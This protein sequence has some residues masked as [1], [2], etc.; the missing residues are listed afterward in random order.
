MKI[1]KILISQPAPTDIDQ[2]PYRNLVNE[3]HLDLTFYKFFTV[4]G[5]PASEFRKNRIH[6]TEY[7]AVIFNSKY[8]VDHF[9][10][11]AKELRE[12]IPETMKYFCCTESIS[13]YLQTYIQYRKRK[14]FFGQQFFADLV[15]VMAKHREENYLFP[16]SDEKQTEYTKLLDKAKF[17]YK[18]A[19]MYR[20]VPKDL[21]QFNI[22]DF[23]LVALFA[24]IGVRS[25]LQNFPNFKDDPIPVAAFGTTTHAALQAAGIKLTIVAPT[26]S[27]PSMAMAIENYINGKQQDAVIIARPMAIKTRATRSKSATV[28]GAKKPKSVFT[29]KAKYKQLMEEKKAK[30]AQRKADRERRK[31]EA[32]DAAA[33]AEKEALS[34]TST[35]AENNI[36]IVAKANK[37]PNNED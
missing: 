27:A 7:S 31:A 4:E 9:F 13:Y 35:A 37:T 29:N 1:N 6:L 20:S 22:K 17:K 12:T 26:K 24:P 30:A 5:I 14:V 11:M 33:K 36:K 28:P 16:C 23:D 21:S 10:R 25:L 15:D 3:Y 34:S 18:K 8:A 2:S 19:P 32:A